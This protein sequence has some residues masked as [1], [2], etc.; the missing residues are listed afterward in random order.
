VLSLPV[1]P[2]AV[3]AASVTVAA[4]YRVKRGDTLGGIAARNHTTVASLVKLNSLRNA[5]VV[6][7]GQLLR[8]NAG[9]TWVCPVAAPVTDVGAFGVVRAP[10]VI[11]QGVDL[12][13][14][15]GTPV[16]ANV[17]GVFTRH[18]NPKGGNAYILRGDDGQTY[19]G[20]HLDAYVANDG[21]VSL[22]QAI[23][24]VG[25]TG[26]AQGTIPHLHFEWWRNGGKPVDPQPLLQGACQEKSA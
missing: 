16:V 3:T 17:S 15:K 18:P 24:R 21:R 1:K 8:L 11:H 22:G 5:N 9:P 20:A 7:E 14:P 19:Y 10:G 6:R 13:A 26:D 25:E 12:A 23:G 2:A 4:T